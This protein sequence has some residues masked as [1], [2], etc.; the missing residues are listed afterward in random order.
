MSDFK[1]TAM[2]D[3]IPPSRKISIKKVEVPLVLPTLPPKPPRFTKQFKLFKLKPQKIKIFLAG[4]LLIFS[5]VAFSIVFSKMKVEITP[6]NV[7]VA[8]DETVEFSFKPFPGKLMSSEISFSDKRSGAFASSQKKSLESKARGTITI[9]NKNLTSQVLVVGTRFESSSGK[10]YKIEKSIVIPA[11]S[12]L[13]A[14]I[15]ADKPGL[16][17]NEEN[18]VDFTI[19]SFKEQRSPKFNTVRAKS[20][21][22]IGGGF[23]GTTLIVGTGDVQNGKAVLLK[24]ALSETGQTLTR[25]TPDDSF[26]LAQS[27]R[28]NVVEENSEPSVGQSGEKFTLNV[29]GVASGVIVN[30][31]SLEK[32]LGKKIPNYDSSSFHFKINNIEN[33]SFMLVGFKPDKPD[34][35]LK[36]AGVAEFVGDIDENL[37]QDSIFEKKF[38]KSSAILEQFPAAS[39][40]KVHFSP[41]WLRLF[42][43]SKDR[44]E[45]T[46]N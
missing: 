15:I 40:I 19:P 3:I 39:R 23:S 13:D 11:N 43:E 22:P 35:I 20:K 26:F 42:P 14:E 10:I 8:L 36:V 24:D 46:S 32:A 2:S 17:F 30:K 37:V 44:I 6:K 34:F 41:F 7:S 31:K 33:L 21:T 27:L 38:K 16:E 25:K 29:T 12:F 28:Y 4:F 9:T 5:Y 45:I 18:L 1:K